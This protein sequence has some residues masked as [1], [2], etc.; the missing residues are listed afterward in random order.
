M[1]GVADSFDDLGRDLLLRTPASHQQREMQ[2]DPQA[3][4][5]LRALF[6]VALKVIDLVRR[7]FA[8]E[9]LIKVVQ[10]AVTCA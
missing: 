4:Q 2:L 1:E 5:A 9:Q 6:Q 10:K 3:L 8:V 7:Q